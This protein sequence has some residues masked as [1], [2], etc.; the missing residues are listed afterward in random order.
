MEATLQERLQ[1]ILAGPD[2]ADASVELSWDGPRLVA[3]VVSASF[4]N[5][6]EAERQAMIWD[7]LEQHLSIDDRLRI[8][9]IF[10]N[11]PREQAA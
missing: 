6:D 8:A 3:S 9:F 4:E 7:L 1:S 2:L 11:S 10:T 5:V